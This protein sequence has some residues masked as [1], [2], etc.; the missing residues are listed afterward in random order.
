MLYLVN[1]REV[2]NFLVAS[3]GSDFVKMSVIFL[4]DG[5]YLNIISPDFV[6]FFMK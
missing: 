5:T 3:Q 1:D 4:A 6:Y 2:T